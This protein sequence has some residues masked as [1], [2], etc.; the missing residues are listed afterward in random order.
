M[1]HKLPPGCV[2]DTDR[3]GNVRT[4]YRG[5]G[6]K[7]RLWRFLI[8]RSCGQLCAQAHAA[9]AIFGKYPHFCAIEQKMTGHFH[10]YKTIT[11]ELKMRHGVQRRR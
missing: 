7:V 3:H 4:Y 1:T 5:K 11:Y 6:R 10:V 2:Q 9:G 8:H